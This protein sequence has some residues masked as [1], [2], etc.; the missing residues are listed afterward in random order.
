VG[1]DCAVVGDAGWDGDRVAGGH[2]DG[3]QVAAG[4]GEVSDV[5]HI[6]ALQ[7]EVARLNRRIESMEYRLSP[8]AP[9]TVPDCEYG[10]DLSTF[11]THQD[12]CPF[13]PET[14]PDRGAKRRD[15]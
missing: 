1:V 7:A 10:C 8:A 12:D 14:A 15:K 3:V 13:D 2:G 6:A 9:K 4:D 11:G 5:D